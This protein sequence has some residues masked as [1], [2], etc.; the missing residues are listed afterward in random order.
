MPPGMGEEIRAHAATLII[1]SPQRIPFTGFASSLA[2]IGDLDGDHFPDYAVG[3]YE[4]HGNQAAK[5][6]RVFIFSGQ[7]RTLLFT[8]DPPALPP[9]VAAAMDPTEGAAFGCALIGVGD[10]DQD[11]VPDL[12]IGAFGQE[13]SGAAYVVSGKTHTL[14]HTLRAPQPQAGAG[15]G[16]SVGVVGDLTGDHIPELLDW[17]LRSRRQWA[18]LCFRWQR[19]PR[20]THLRS[21][22]CFGRRGIWLVRGWGWRPRS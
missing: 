10:I 21:S 16:W 5:Q 17:C 15:F 9:E 19:R 2:I 20:L 6:G 1:E 18:R 7:R 12:L 8:L 4:Y 22:A 13:K 11:T 3:A 14:L